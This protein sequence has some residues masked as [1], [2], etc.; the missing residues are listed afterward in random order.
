MYVFQLYVPEPKPLPL[1]PENLRFETMDSK[2]DNLLNKVNRMDRGQEHNQGRLESRFDQIDHA[3]QRLYK[4]LSSTNNR[5]NENL[6]NILSNIDQLKSINYE[7]GLN[8]TK[9]L[10]RTTEMV[11]DKNESDMVDL[12]VKIEKYIKTKKNDLSL[13]LDDV[14]QFLVSIF[15]FNKNSAQKHS[16]MINDLKNVTMYNEIGNGGYFIFER[17]FL[18]SHG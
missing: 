3:N 6:P 16:E 13:K 10:N 18:F 12:V 2:L 15:S 1:T 14:H 17:F 4:V 8:V 5:M 7:I 9:N 11:I